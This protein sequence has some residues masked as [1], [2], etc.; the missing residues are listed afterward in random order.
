MPKRFFAAAIV[1]G[2]AALAL[3]GAACSDDEPPPIEGSRWAL[4]S[5]G[6]E[7]SPASVLEGTTITAEFDAGEMNVTGSAGCNTYFGEYEVDGNDLSIGPLAS[8]ERACL[9]PDPTKPEVGQ[10]I[11]GQEQSFL[12]ALGST[13]R[14]EVEGGV[15]TIFTIDDQVLIFSSQ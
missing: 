1:G 6:P 5:F 12:A 2:A 13:R 4:T 15:L 11:M 3:F 7:G 9:G 14:H 8:T 10:Q